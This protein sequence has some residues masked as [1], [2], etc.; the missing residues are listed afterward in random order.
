MGKTIFDVL[1]D[2]LEE[3]KARQVQPLSAGRCV[4]FAEYKESCGVIR[5]LTIAQQEIDDLA[6]ANRGEDDDE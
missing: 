1:Q 4:D 5:G 3:A 6:K 2:K